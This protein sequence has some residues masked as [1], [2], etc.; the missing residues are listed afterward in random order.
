[1][2]LQYVRMFYELQDRYF[3]LNLQKKQREKKFNEPV[4]TGVHKYVNI[5]ILCLL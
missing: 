5:Y 2:Q 4:Q 1:M 3:P